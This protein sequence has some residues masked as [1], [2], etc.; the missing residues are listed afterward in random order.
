[1]YELNGISFTSPV[2]LTVF[3]LN[4]NGTVTQFGKLK[5]YSLKIYDS[6]TLIRDFIP[7]RCSN[8]KFG[9]FDRV[10]KRFYTNAGTDEFI[11]EVT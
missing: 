4:N 11:A 9:L 3:A 6:N 5:L 8:N 1:M 7:C 2:S 10:Q